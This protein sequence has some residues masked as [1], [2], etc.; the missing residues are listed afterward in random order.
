MVQTLEESAGVAM[1]Y[2]YVQQDEKPSHKLVIEGRNN[3]RLALDSVRFLGALNSL[4]A[5]L[6]QWDKY[7]MPDTKSTAGAIERIRTAFHST[8]E[9][10]YINLDGYEESD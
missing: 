3:I 5:Q 10:Y 4:S 9:D 8:L 2:T 6:R 1:E 7:G